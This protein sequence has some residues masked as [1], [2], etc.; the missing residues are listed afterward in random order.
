M[1]VPV[2]YFIL[3]SIMPKSNKFKVERVNFL[4]RLKVKICHVISISLEVIPARVCFIQ[5]S[6][7]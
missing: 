2:D 6:V 3:V 7:V 1:K 4:N 5:Y